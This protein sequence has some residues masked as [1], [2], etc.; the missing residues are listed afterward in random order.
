VFKAL[1]EVGPNNA[2]AAKAHAHG[3]CV[4]TWMLL[5]DEQCDV[6]TVVSLLHLLLA[7]VKVVLVGSREVKVFA[8]TKLLSLYAMFFSAPPCQ[9]EQYNR[10]IIL[11]ISFVHTSCPLSM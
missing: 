8:E 3:L 9:A 5:E 10:S 7:R 11:W 6:I 2:R 1:C 4:C